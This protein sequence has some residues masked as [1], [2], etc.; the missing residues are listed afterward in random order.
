[1]TSILYTENNGEESTTENNG[2]E[3]TNTQ[4]RSL[5]LNLKRIQL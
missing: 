3:S 5:P 2:E 1:M 4:E